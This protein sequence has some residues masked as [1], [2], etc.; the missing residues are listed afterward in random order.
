MIPIHPGCTRS[1]KLG[2]IGPIPLDYTRLT[3]RVARHL[4]FRPLGTYLYLRVRRHLHFGRT[5]TA[6]APLSFLIIYW[7]FGISCWSTLP[8]FFQYILL[9]DPIDHLFVIYLVYLVGWSHYLP[10]RDSS[11]VSYWS[12]SLSYCQTSF[13]L[14]RA[15]RI[16][17]ISHQLRL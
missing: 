15:T 6:T 2:R 9:I 1:I 3:L 17:M 5:F 4:N 14:L 13:T 8:S 7:P 11:D 16:P 12:N 10:P